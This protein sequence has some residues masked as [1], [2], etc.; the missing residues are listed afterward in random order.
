M[1]PG[2]YDISMAEYLAI[3]AFSSGL[4]HTILS[5]SPLHAW[6]KSWLN[7][8]REREE[9]KTA[10]IGTVAHAAL[11]EGN[12]DFVVW[13][14]R[15]D[16]PGE[17]GGIPVGWTTKA[18]KEARDATYA[19]GKTPILTDDKAAI[20]A[21]VAAA[22]S[23]IAGSE[24][25]GVFDSGKAEQTIT[26][27]EGDILCKSRPDWLSDNYLLHYK[28]TKGSVNP[29]TFSR[30]AT[31]SGYDLAMMFYLRGL[32]AVLPDS[33][34][35]HYLLAQEQS[36]PYACKLFDLS[37]PLADVAAHKA[38]RAINAWASC[39]KSGKWPA[40]DGSVHSIE[41]AP[42]DLAKEEQTQFT[43]EELKDGIPL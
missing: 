36:E 31:N 29:Q 28:T 23:Y 7:P 38:G 37:G 15:N 33:Q 10:D 11:L 41:L 34:A 3:P 43:E 8:N 2:I 9:S 19:E 1:N 26:W 42:W 16:Y 20:D 35:Q 12:F 24:I 18:I 40:Y 17:K 21:M 39:M 4:A 13:I 22:K 14:D 27:Q 25:A 32:E 6:T 30:L 5:A